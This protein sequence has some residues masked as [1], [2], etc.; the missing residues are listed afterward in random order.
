MAALAVAVARV[1]RLARRGVAG[2]GRAAGG[3]VVGREAVARGVGA[4]AAGAGVGAAGVTCR[5]RVG[6]RG[7]RVGRG[8][9]VGAV[10]LVG[11]AARALAAGGGAVP[12]ADLAAR[13]GWIRRGW[14]EALRCVWA[15]LSRARGRVAAGVVAGLA[16]DRRVARV[17]ARVHRS[18]RAG[19]VAAALRAGL[20]PRR[21]QGV[22]GRSGG[23]SCRRRCGVVVRS[24]EAWQ[25]AHATGPKL[26][27]EIV[28]V[29]R[30]RGRRVRRVGRR[31]RVRR[32]VA[33]HAVGGLGP[34]GLVVVAQRAAARPCRRRRRG[35]RSGRCRGSRLPCSRARSGR[36]VLRRCSRCDCW[37][38]TRPVQRG[39]WRRSPS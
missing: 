14:R 30:A 9:A 22:L 32:V 28:T 38:G 35:C 5:D 19:R 3:R 23:R 17:D 27:P 36:R 26:W 11:V 33:A 20:V 6:T 13:A 8:G 21:G 1:A 24:G 15:R 12:V 2:T 39:G 29:C 31:M 34:V 7:E 18:G 25:S 10:D 16:R 4:V 37:C